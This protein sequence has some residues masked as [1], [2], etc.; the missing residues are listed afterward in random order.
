MRPSTARLIRRL[1]ALPLMILPLGGC[2]LTSSFLDPYGPVAAAQRALF[3]HVIGWMMIVLVPVFVLVPLFAWRYRRGNT[4]AVYRPNWQFSWPLEILV[5]GVPIVVVTVLSALAIAKELRLDPYA[6]L[7]P[8]RPPLEIQVVGLD[9]KWLFIYP[10]QGI[11]TV[12]VAA[13][14]S[15]RAVR[16]RL[17]SDTVMQS[18]FI[19]SL[20]SQLYAMA[21]MVTDL[22]LKADRIGRLRG[23]NTQFNGAGFQEQGFTLAAMRPPDFDVWVQSVRAAGKPLDDAAYRRLSQQS[24]LTQARAALGSDAMPPDALYFAGVPPNLFDA[25]V[26]KYRHMAGT[27]H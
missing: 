6:P 5:W 18:F 17:T 22:N 2:S 7:Q 25:I 26:G 19:P 8:P 24:T 9:W 12:G 1:S 10:A 14:P 3:F 15:D 23:L 27:G 20:G 16:F 21:G 4:A 11:A 13:V